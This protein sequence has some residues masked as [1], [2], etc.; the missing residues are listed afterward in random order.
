MLNHDLGLARL[1]KLRP[2]NPIIIEHLVET[3]V[4]RAKAF[5]DG[6]LEAQGV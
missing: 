1:P 2:N 4:P 5:L 3:D 6:K